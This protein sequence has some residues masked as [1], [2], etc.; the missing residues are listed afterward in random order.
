MFSRNPQ[1]FRPRLF[2][3]WEF[4]LEEH[5]LIWTVF[6]E[7]DRYI[8]ARLNLHWIQDNE[9][10]SELPED[11][12]FVTHANDEHCQLM[13][14]QRLQLEWDVLVE[15]NLQNAPTRK[16]IY[17]IYKSAIKNNSIVGILQ[18]VNNSE[19]RT[20]INSNELLQSQ[21]TGEQ[22]K[23]M[24]LNKI[25]DDVLWKEEIGKSGYT[26]YFVAICKNQGE[27]FYSRN[28]LF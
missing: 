6:R 11:V 24:R 5:Y 3:N 1:V 20:N 19:T 2:S 23:K 21:L 10:V 17:C 14:E 26:A 13:Q 25:S 16:E 4:W 22:K 8:F 9:T 15:E 12:E 7:V 27:Q 18:K 28:D